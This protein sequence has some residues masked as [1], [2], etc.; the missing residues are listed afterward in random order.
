ME[1][2]NSWR[3]PGYMS[4]MLPVLTWSLSNDLNNKIFLTDSIKRVLCSSLFG[5]MA[6]AP[7]SSSA[8]FSGS[9]VS[10]NTDLRRVA[11]RFTNGSVR[12]KKKNK[13]LLSTRIHY[14]L[15][16]SWASCKN[17]KY[18]WNFKGMYEIFEGNHEQ[19]F[20]LNNLA[21]SFRVTH[22]DF[23]LVINENLNRIAFRLVS[24]FPPASSQ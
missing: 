20:N 6:A 13:P 19:P 7:S 17:D 11:K 1:K 23:L 18:H 21:E 4:T 9:Y 12:P 8:S 22:Y 3:V 10:A 14:E 2:I 5:K 24:F 16:H 15:E